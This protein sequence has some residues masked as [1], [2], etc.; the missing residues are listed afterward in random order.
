M[1]D[2]TFGEVRLLSTIKHGG[3]SAMVWG[4]MKANG[5]DNVFIDGPMTAD[6][7][8]DILCHNLK[9]S[10]QALVLKNS[11]IFQQDIDPKHCCS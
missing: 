3:A 5:V 6:V 9:T 4:C 7:V 2:S 10:A 1:E 8:N 11:S